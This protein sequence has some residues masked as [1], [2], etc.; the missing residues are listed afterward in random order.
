MQYKNNNNMEFRTEFT[1][2]RQVNK[3][4][5]GVTAR[6]NKLPGG[7]IKTEV[8]IENE[9]AARLCRKPPGRYVTYD[10]DRIS[11]EAD[12][13]IA[14]ALASTLKSML[15]RA[16]RILVAGMGNREMTADAL[17]PLAAGGLITGKRG[18]R[19]LM[20]VAPGV[21]GTT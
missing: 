11:P 9:E 20:G 17:G 2:D 18:G 7:V 21:S 6:E 16:K 12:G 10:A 4:D 8:V 5:S 19:E 3:S 14:D 1:Y 15:A 13:V